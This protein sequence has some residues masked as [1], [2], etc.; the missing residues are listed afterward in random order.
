MHAAFWHFLRP[1]SENYWIASVLV[2]ATQT[3]VENCCQKFGQCLECSSSMTKHK[4]NLGKCNTA[5]T[6]NDRKCSYWLKMKLGI[7]FR[8]CFSAVCFS[9]EKRPYTQ[10]IMCLIQL[11]ILCNS[12]DRYY[13]PTYIPHRIGMKVLKDLKKTVVQQWMLD[14]CFFFGHAMTVYSSWVLYICDQYLN[15]FQK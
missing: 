10:H 15:A 13:V 6:E 9:W 7:S 1:R 12:K 8:S 4:L 2:F 5:Q 11:S 14:F 3:N